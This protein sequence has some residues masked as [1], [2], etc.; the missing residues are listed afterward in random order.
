MRM[1][2]LGASGCGKSVTL[3]CIAGIMTPDRGH[4][5]LD[6]ETLFDSEKHINLPPQKRRVGYLF[7]QYALFPNMTVLQN[8]QC[9]IR[10]GSR[11]ERRRRAEE[12]LR[13]F[14]LEGLEKKYPAQLSGGQQQRTAP[15]ERTTA[16]FNILADKCLCYK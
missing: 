14:R 3:K 6:G 1:A 2:L 15:G 13:R 16:A 8:I 10:S 11:A 7:Q 12:P 9:G 4:I 5:I